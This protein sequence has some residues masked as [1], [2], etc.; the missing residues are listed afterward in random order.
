VNAADLVGAP[1]ARGGRSLS[2]GFDCR[3]LV[4]FYLVEV[5]GLALEA[6]AFWTLDDLGATQAEAEAFL[7]RH[8]DEWAEEPVA[9]LERAPAGWVAHQ[10]PT[11]E[12]LDH[13]SVSIGGGLFL[14]TARST[15]AVIVPARR[16]TRV[17]RLFRYAR[18]R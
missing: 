1:F 5:L 4:R 16:L 9:L 7:A 13:L 18:Q 17:R 12:G 6:D 8:G 10:G 11:S 3:T 15:G 14:T 2:E